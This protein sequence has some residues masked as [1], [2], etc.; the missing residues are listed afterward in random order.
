MLVFSVYPPS[1]TP[2]Y[3]EE[4]NL[5]ISWTA[6]KNSMF[7]ELFCERSN[8]FGRDVQEEYRTNE[9]QRQNEHNKWISEKQ[10]WAL[11]I[12]IK[13]TSHLHSKSRRIIR[14]EL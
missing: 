11:T 3:F 8:E 7:H 13:Q 5:L 6:G 10:R 4:D 2:Q 12:E 9:R 14:V 1:K